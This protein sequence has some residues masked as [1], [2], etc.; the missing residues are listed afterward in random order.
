MYLHIFLFITLVYLIRLHY[1]YGMN[2]QLLNGKKILTHMPSHNIS[3]PKHLWIIIRRY[4]FIQRQ[5]CHAKQITVI[6]FD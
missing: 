1:K 2:V 4:A 6:I 3:G 5:D